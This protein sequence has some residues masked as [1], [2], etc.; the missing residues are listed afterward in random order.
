MSTEFRHKCKAAEKAYDVSKEKTTV[1]TE[2]LSAPRAASVGRSSQPLINHAGKIQSQSARSPFDQTSNS[3]ESF[4]SNA[5]VEHVQSASARANRSLQLAHPVEQP[6]SA[7]LVSVGRPSVLMKP[8]T[9]VPSK[10]LVVSTT[11][12]P[13]TVTAAAEKS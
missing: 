3:L 9:M 2:Q 10:A 12:V 7:R 13:V 11:I 6:S 4:S 1:R 8:L 5:A